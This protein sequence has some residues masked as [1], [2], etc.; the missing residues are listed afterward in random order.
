MPAAEPRNRFHSWMFDEALPFWARS[1]PDAEF[2][3]V[4]EE[5]ALDGRDAAREFKR[6]RVAGRQIYVFSHAALLGWSE[7]SRVVDTAGSWLMEQAWT[8]RSFVRRTTR[9]GRILDP[10]PDLYDHAFCLFGFAWAFKASGQAKWADRAHLCL[11]SIEARFETRA[12]GEIPPLPKGQWRLQ[13][14]YMHLL[15]ACLIACEAGLGKRYAD[16][17]ASVLGM[18]EQRFFQ[19][20]TGTLCEYFDTDWNPAPGPDGR[21]VEP[22]HQFEW[23][24]ILERCDHVLGGDRSRAARALIETA[25]QLGRCPVSGAVRNVV[26]DDGEIVDGGSRTWPNTERMKAGI[27]LCRFAGRPDG[28]PDDFER[29]RAMIEQSGA[30]LL[31]RYL[32]PRSGFPIPAGT[33]IDAFD[34]NGQACA[35]S[36]PASTLYHVFLAF[37]EA[38][39]LPDERP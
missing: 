6:T 23:A 14:P 35:T 1:A 24:W 20:V 38:C 16:I 29:G 8:G 7:G 30:L 19:P 11:E 12:N 28:K 32:S 2:G 3:G 36:I 9:E 13:N 5:L 10:T 33:W 39:A 15:E 18:F 31:D 25:E 4:V 26:R 34:A 17:A 22:G 21:L 27:A 37:A